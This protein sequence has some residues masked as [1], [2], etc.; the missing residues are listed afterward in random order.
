MG[1]DS[2]FRKMCQR[3]LDQGWEIE[4]LATGHY[5]FLSPEGRT[6][7]A[8]G[9][10]GDRRARR[11]LRADL[12]RAGLK[13][14]DPRPLRAQRREARCSE[15]TRDPDGDDPRGPDN[16][17]DGDGSARGPGAD[18]AA[19]GVDQRSSPPGSAETGSPASD[20][21]AWSGAA[22]M[23]A[24]QSHE[25]TV[26]DLAELV[27]VSR[28]TVYCWEGGGTP[29]T[30]HRTALAALFPDLASGEAVRET[31]YASGEDRARDGVTKVEPTTI[32]S[33]NPMETTQPSADEVAGVPP[34]EV[35][36]PEDTEPGD[37]RANYSGV[38]FRAAVRSARKA[39]G[40]TMM[41]LSARVGCSYSAIFSWEH[42]TAPSIEYLHKLVAALPELHDATFGTARVRDVLEG[43]RTR[44]SGMAFADALREECKRQGRPN[45]LRTLQCDP[46][47]L[48]SWE[49]GE[50]CPG[51]E[52][53]AA[54]HEHY[55][56]L[57]SAAPPIRRHCVDVRPGVAKARSVKGKRPAMR[58]RESSASSSTSAP[59]EPGVR[60]DPAANLANIKNSQVRA[61]VARLLGQI[62]NGQV[63]LDDAL[64]LIG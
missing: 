32:D 4:R 58:T 36:P 26:A 45:V 57:G 6:V 10:P 33:M 38:P 51:K 48:R 54:L 56:A 37:D 11:A 8:S 62:K 64:A 50:A 9:T 47:T 60:R 21:P 14:E 17:V 31:N 24:R 35:Q 63:A 1:W 3:A 29:S 39:Q 25:L 18:S 43:D 46:T 27:G 28:S 2:D 23:R 12:R 19:G 52:Y 40:L 22:L 16:C 49:C 15:A 41:H 42:G 7:I 30:A 34:V 20:A 61:D 53:L 5:R 59:T 13:D 55:P 44:Y